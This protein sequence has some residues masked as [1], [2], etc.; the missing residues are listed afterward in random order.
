MLLYHM[1][2]ARVKILIFYFFVISFSC[3]YCTL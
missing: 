2:T 1:L 3:K